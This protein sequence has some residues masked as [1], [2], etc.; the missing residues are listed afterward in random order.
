[1]GAL[2]GAVMGVGGAL[3]MLAALMS[4]LGMEEEAE[5][6]STVAMVFMTLGTVLTTLNNIA[7]MLGVSFT[8]AGA[9]IATAGVTA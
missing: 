8:T 5:A 3:G 2:G 1:M 9:Q 6:V 7:P 4:K